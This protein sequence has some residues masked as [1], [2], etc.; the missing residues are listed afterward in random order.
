MASV[1]RLLRFLLV[2]R[3]TVL[4]NQGPSAVPVFELT[5]VAMSVP[6]LRLVRVIL[7]VIVNFI[8]LRAVIC[9]AGKTRTGYSFLWSASFALVVLVYFIESRFVVGAAHIH[10]ITSTI[11]ACTSLSAGWFLWNSTRGT[12]GHG[13]RLLAGLFLLLGLHGIDRPLWSE[14]PLFL[15]RLAFDHLL[16]VSLGIAMVVLV[17]ERARARTDELNDKLRRLSLLTASSTQT[18][19]VRALLDLVLVNVVGSLGVSHG[20]VRLLEGEGSSAKLVVRA[21]VG[22][23][24]AYLAK[25]KEIPASASWAQRV[26]KEEFATMNVANETDKQERDR[27]LATGVK[28]IVSLVLRGKDAPLGIFAV[29]Y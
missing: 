16:A 5:Q 17:L 8:F 11:L 25:E 12:K 20:I 10:W 1:L 13:A 9:Y 4:E 15:L 21:A 28:E 18:L 29:G 19:S 14:S 7:L 2:R 26:L 22:F 23:D 24:E 6:Q 3:R 27:M